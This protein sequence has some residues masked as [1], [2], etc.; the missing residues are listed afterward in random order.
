[1]SNY[2]Q[3]IS[4]PTAVTNYSNN[5][6]SCEHVT[7]TNF[8]ELGVAKTLELAPKQSIDVDMTTF[9]R[10]N[11]L[12]LPT[13]GSSRI[14][15]R[16]YFVPYRTI[17]PYWDDFINDSPH[18]FSTDSATLIPDR[19]PQI[20][21]SDFVNLFIDTNVTNQDVDLPLVDP[22]NIILNPTKE[23]ADNC[24]FVYIDINGVANGYYLTKFGKRVY[25]LINQL[26]YRIDFNRLNTE[27]NHSALPLFALAKVYID[28]YFPSQYLQSNIV[29]NISKWFTYNET[30]DDF[31]NTF[32]HLKLR[33]I[34][35][36]IERVCYDSDYFVSSWDNPNSPNLG[37]ASDVVIK[38]INRTVSNDKSADVVLESS[39]Y[40]SAPYLKDVNG[41]PINK[42]SQYALNALRSLTDYMKRH[43]IVG[44][45]VLDRYLSRWGVVLSSEK[46][47]RSVQLAK[48]TQALKI[49]DVTSLA[50]TT[51]NSLNS[52]QGAT[53]GAFAGKG[54][55]QGNFNFSFETD[56][57]G[58]V[59]IISTVV[60]RAAYY[61]GQ[62]RTT[63]HT[64]RLDFYTPEFD[65]L[66][67]QALATREVFC[68]SNSYHQYPSQNFV[69]D[70]RF[71][72][73]NLIFGYVPR[74]AEYKR[75]MDNITGDVVLGS[76]N[77]GLQGWTMFRDVL[78]FFSDFGI[79]AK[80]NLSFVQGDDAEQYDR[81]FNRYST[82]ENPI[83]Q[84][85]VYHLMSI[86][87]RFP[88]KSL[89]DDYEFESEDK[90]KKV[91]VDVGG[92][93]AN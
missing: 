30:P 58:M 63:M 36:S 73:N 66:G 5:D 24:D 86:K 59:I 11:P 92:V 46:L 23:Q 72:Y 52:S 13:Y 64:T 8:M 89:F 34:F 37:G 50:D 82:D 7:S 79:N 40:D 22:D 6:L 38:D 77:T 17:C 21:N 61:Q 87:S 16:A 70:L 83:D 27:F 62:D 57:F 93:R 68:P 78:P 85:N 81:I 33:E 88:G 28:F 55:S 32:N 39:P 4:L 35:K 60:P 2:P 25:K 10:L 69:N 47:K 12:T 74:Y 90:A 53:L 41:Q 18:V 26:G 42:V 49:G 14:N 65:N 29:S 75:G 31:Y 19:I 3:K 20:K 1:M 48:S 9:A 91:S 44:S 15:T 51:L 56:E 80:H 67:V 84:I 54:V 43:Q 71:N 45:R 76:V